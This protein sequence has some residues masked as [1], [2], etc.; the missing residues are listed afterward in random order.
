[1]TPS[2]DMPASGM[3]TEWDLRNLHVDDN[4]LEELREAY[5]HLALHVC[6][7]CEGRTYV[8]NPDARWERD[9]DGVDYC[10]DDEDM[11]CPRCNGVGYEAPQ[12]PKPEPHQPTV[13]DQTE[14]PF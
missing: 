14:E 6:R 4:R 8:A 11:E 13:F 3:M 2:P 9:G 7:E 5:E 10:M 1:M 12:R